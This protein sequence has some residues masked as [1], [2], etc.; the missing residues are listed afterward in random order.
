ML[1]RYLLPRRS[2]L[3]AAALLA[4]AFALGIAT[5]QG[6]AASPANVQVSVVGPSN[7]VRVGDQ[8]T[9]A[10]RID[11][12]ADAGAFEFEFGF[13]PAVASTT[14]A[15]IHLGPFLDSTGRTTGELRL[16]SSPTAPDYPLYGAYSY[17][18][19]P[20]PSGNGLLATVTMLATA[21]GTSILD[22]RSL[23]VT[24]V[25]GE[26]VATIGVAGSVQVLGALRPSYLP[27]IRRGTF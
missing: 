24:N 9:V 21:T 23:K 15:D 25:A 1:R 3:R 6:R 13:T 8:F 19:Q 16:G 14:A 18:A 20:G 17:G 5:T 22:V 10:I 2:G 12:A 11:E 27:L 4:L 26:E 7:P